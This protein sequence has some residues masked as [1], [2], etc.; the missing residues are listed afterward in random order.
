VLYSGRVESYQ[1]QEKS[2]KGVNQIQTVNQAKTYLNELSCRIDKY[3]ALWALFI[4]H[5]RLKSIYDQVRINDI[6]LK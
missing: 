1:T 4:L 3:T 6:E 5:K 2:Q